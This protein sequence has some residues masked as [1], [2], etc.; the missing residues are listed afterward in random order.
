MASRDGGRKGESGLVSALIKA[1][2]IDAVADALRQPLETGEVA[3][4][5]ARIIA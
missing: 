2:I 4:T 1:L 5:R 3:I